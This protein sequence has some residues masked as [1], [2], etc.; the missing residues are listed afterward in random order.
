MSKWKLI[1]G[2]WCM[3]PA[4]PKGIIE[5]IGGSYLASAP[6]ISYKRLIEGLF[7]KNLAIHAWRYIPSFDHQFQAVQAWKSFRECKDILCSRISEAPPS[8]R[9]GHSLGCKL[10]LLSPDLGRNSK[11]LVALSFNNFNVNKSIPMIS[12][13]KRKLNVVSEFSPSPSETMKLISYKYLQPKN[14]LIKFKNDSID[15]SMLLLRSLQSRKFDESSILELEGNHL[16]PA[17][18]GIRKTLLG[19][20]IDNDKKSTTIKNIVH[21]ID[22]LFTKN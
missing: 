10:H 22:T 9:V 20:V 4:K 12:K 15:Q 16:T 18:I 1:E 14:L 17:S 7:K 19:E 13:V 5:I 3:W 21:A 2:T 6:H 8:I 11:S